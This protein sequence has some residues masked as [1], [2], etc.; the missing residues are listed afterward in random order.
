[1]SIDEIG[2]ACYLGLKADK[3]D[4]KIIEQ[5]CSIYLWLDYQETL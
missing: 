5:T 2:E 3:A 1:M 4:G